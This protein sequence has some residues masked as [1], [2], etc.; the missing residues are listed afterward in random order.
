MSEFK[1]WLRN[2][3]ITVDQF[4]NTLALG[5]PDETISSRLGKAARRGN[6]VAHVMCHMIGWL[7]GPDH[8][9]HAIEEDEGM[10]AVA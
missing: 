9:N 6:K 5:D 1:H 7:L 10:E 3:L 8:C 2:F 4:L